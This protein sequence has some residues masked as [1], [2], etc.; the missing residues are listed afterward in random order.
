[1]KAP[2][3]CTSVQNTATPAITFVDMP[4]FGHG[5][6]ADK[7]IAAPKVSSTNEIAAASSAPATMGPHSR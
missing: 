1:M 5:E 7:P 3:C 6:V 4:E 2:I